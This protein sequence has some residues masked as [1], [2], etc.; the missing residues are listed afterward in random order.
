MDPELAVDV[1]RDPIARELASAMFRLLAEVGARTVHLFDGRRGGAAGRGKCFGT[2]FAPVTAS[3]LA[4]QR[5]LET[6]TPG[7]TLLY[8]DAVEPPYSLVSELGTNNT[9]RGSR[10]STVELGPTAGVCFR[11]L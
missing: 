3:S 2:V 1:V 5:M 7:W 6:D 9:S 4:G 8:T 11:Q 10:G